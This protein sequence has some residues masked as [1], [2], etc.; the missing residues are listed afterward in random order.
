MGPGHR[1]RGQR[2]R[3]ADR[4]FEII[5]VF[6]RAK[7]A[8]T[9]EAIA[10]ELETSRRTVY[11]DIAA[12][13]ERRVP[14]RGEAGYGYVLEGGFDLPALMFTFD[15]IEALVL[16]AQW[17]STHAD[18]SLSRAAASLLAKVSSVV[19]EPVRGAIESS[20][21]GTMPSYATNA[22]DRFDFERLRAWSRQGRKLRLTYVDARGRASERTVW[23]CLIGFLD[24]VRVVVAWCELREGF[25]IFRD[26]RLQSVDF[27]QEHYPG[28]GRAL[29]RRWLQDVGNRRAGTALPPS[30]PDSP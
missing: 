14:I 27:L 6:R 13:I 7:G 25:R 2:M 1:L 3:R 20:A 28:G 26:D 10:R 4:L 15:E 18:P 19:P 9:A 29:R 17:V 23:P 8:L 16:G 11:R 22:H 12:L 21:V 5:Q 30:P 24:S